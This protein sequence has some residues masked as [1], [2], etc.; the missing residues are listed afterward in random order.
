ME[1]QKAIERIAEDHN[2]IIRTKDIVNA[3]LRREV[4]PQL[5]K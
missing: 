5:L 1:I 3:G 4:L 2:G